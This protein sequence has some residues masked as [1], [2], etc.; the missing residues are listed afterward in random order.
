MKNSMIITVVDKNYRE[1]GSFKRSFDNC[2]ASGNFSVCRVQVAGKRF[3]RIS[4]E[5][6]LLV[7]PDHPATSEDGTNFYLVCWLEVMKL[8][9]NYVKSCTRENLNAF[10]IKAWRVHGQ[11]SSP[12]G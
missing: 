6:D 5:R 3:N 10:D 9:E 7:Y 4:C 2:Q 11:P 8:Y 12:I 1:I